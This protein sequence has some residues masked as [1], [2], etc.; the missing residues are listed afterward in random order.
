MPLLRSSF[1]IVTCRRLNRPVA[2]F[3][4][5]VLVAFLESQRSDDWSARLI[6]EELELESLI[7]NSRR[8]GLTTIQFDPRPDGSGGTDMSLAELLR[9]NPV[10]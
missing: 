7:A 10:E 8:E 4:T 2:F 6:S 9:A 1:W 3:S 5:E